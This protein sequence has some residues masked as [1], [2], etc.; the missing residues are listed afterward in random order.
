MLDHLR[1]RRKGCLKCKCSYR[2]IDGT[3]CVWVSAPMQYCISSERISVSEKD[4]KWNFKHENTLKSMSGKW[5]NFSRPWPGW[6]LHSE[7]LNQSQKL[8]SFDYPCYQIIYMYKHI[9]YAYC[10][11][12]FGPY[13]VTIHLSLMSNSSPRCFILSS[14]QSKK[15]KMQTM[16][17]SLLVAHCQVIFLWVQIQSR[18]FNSLIQ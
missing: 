1:G 16:K 9:A 5:G 13:Y 7:V 6:I 18:S 2:C 14:S 8:S 15:I 10:I 4:L 11:V 3:S 17:K 12:Y